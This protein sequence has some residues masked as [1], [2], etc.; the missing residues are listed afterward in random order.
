[1]W[2]YVEDDAT[3]SRRGLCLNCTCTLTP[4]WEEMFQW[5]W[6]YLVRSDNANRSSCTF[7]VE[8]PNVFVKIFLNFI[9]TRNA[10]S[11]VDKVIA[12]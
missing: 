10:R 1:M 2:E 11:Y 5:T 6:D 12:I 8:L 3:W 7:L 9:R 4:Y